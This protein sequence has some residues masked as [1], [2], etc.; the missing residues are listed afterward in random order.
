MARVQYV[1]V[2]YYRSRNV[3]VDGAVGGKTNTIMRVD[4]GT[5]VFDLGPNKNYTPG[6][7]RRKVQGTT[8]IR[9]LVLPFEPVKAG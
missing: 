7:Y 5:H 8:A 6:E 9:P 4:Q 2:K 1:R 3:H